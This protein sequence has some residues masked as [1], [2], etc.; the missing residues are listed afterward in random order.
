MTQTPHR[1]A[2]FAPGIAP[3]LTRSI[4]RVPSNSKKTLATFPTNASM[5]AIGQSE[6]DIRSSSGRS[7]LPQASSPW[8]N[9]KFW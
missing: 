8:L 5:A 9:Y 1:A 7:D 4:H 2:S 3:G 6:L